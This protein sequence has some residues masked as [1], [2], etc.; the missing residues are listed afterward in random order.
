MR[1]FKGA[2]SDESLFKAEAKI[3]QEIVMYY[4]NSFCL[5]HHKPRS[6]I[7]S[8][9]NEGRGAASLQLMATGLYPGCGDLFVLH[10]TAHCERCIE[11][12]AIR[13]ILLF[14][15]CKSEVGVQ[16]DKQKAFQEH[17]EAMGIGYHIVRS[18]DE[19]KQVI[20]NL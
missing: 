4:R 5:K 15:E 14:F 12:N 17:C 1:N 13:S 3:Q 10:R 2:S 18:L 9:P 16:S 20:E 19:F 8:I 7:F 6:M 11:I